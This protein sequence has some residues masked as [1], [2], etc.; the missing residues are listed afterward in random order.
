MGADGKLVNLNIKYKKN[1]TGVLLFKLMVQ[2]GDLQVTQRIWTRT[3]KPMTEQ[4]VHEF[5]MTFTD[6][7]GAAYYMQFLKYGLVSEIF[8]KVLN[9]EVVSPNDD[10]FL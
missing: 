3:T 1:R 7:E 8:G 5:D 9:Q 6:T 4:N 2:T 10:Y